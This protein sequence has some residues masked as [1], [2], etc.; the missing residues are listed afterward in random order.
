VTLTEEHRLGLSKDG[1]NLFQKSMNLGGEIKVSKVDQIKFK[2]S[3][4]EKAA[5]ANSSNKKEKNRV[6][7]C[8]DVK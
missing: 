3:Y 6:F 8:K 5:Q 7:K 1:T 4:M 2:L